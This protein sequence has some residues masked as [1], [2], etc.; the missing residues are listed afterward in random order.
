MNLNKKI[1]STLVVSAMLSASTV[2]AA[3]VPAGT[4]LAKKQDI[5]INN[6]SEPGSLDP[7][8]IQGVPGSHIAMQQFEGLINQDANGA[9]VPGVAK[10]WD[11]KDNKVFTFHLRDNAKWSNGKP[12]TAQDFVFAWR[13]LVDPKTASPYSYY[14]QLTGMENVDAII[15][16]KMDPSKLG[17][18][19][20]DDHTLQVTLSHSVPYFVKMMANSSVFPVYP[21]V[22]EK[23][24]DKWTQPQ[25]IVSNGAYKLSKWVVNSRIVLVRNPDYWNNKK[26]VINKVTFL[27]VSDQVAA[28]NR[29]MAGEIDMTYEVPNEQ[30]KHLQKDYPNDLKVTGYLCNYYYDFNNK[31]P[32]FNDVRLRKALSYAIN[33]DVI[34]KYVTGKGE[35]P[36]Y[37]FTPAATDGFTPPNLAYAHMTQA[38]RMAKA[39]EWMKEAGY[40]KGGKQLDISILYNTSGNHKKIA[41]AVAQMWKSLGVKVTLENQEWK[42]FL[43]TRQNHQFTVARD[44]WCGDYNE[45]STFMTLMMTGN[46]QNNADY[47]DKAYDALMN[48]ALNTADDKA[49]NALYTKAEDILVNDAPIAPIYSYV[50]ARLVK[51]TVGGYPMHNALDYYYVKNFYMKAKK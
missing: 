13:R 5:V 20:L 49:R 33:R 30:F 43:Q 38:Q 45:A 47:S 1:L 32:P 8:L 31:K 21:P 23:W 35:Q 7:Q 17:V 29:F 22:V 6:G 41:L 28:M 16:G 48:K 36:L 12:V 27:P 3:D 4:Q 18:K 34:T 51:P 9:T 39:R 15:D 24:G 40:G 2:Y 46:T 25:H 37:G 26:T 42:T 10:S 14:L 44:A 11:N 19:A 50:N